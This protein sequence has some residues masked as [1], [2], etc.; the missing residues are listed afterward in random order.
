MHSMNEFLPTTPFDIYELA[1]FRLVVQNGSFT[2]AAAA[3]GLT[4]S[5]ITRQVQG[6]EGSLGL[7]LLERTTRSVHA[8]PAGEFLFRESGRVLGDVEQT[9]R[10]LREE[11][12]GARKEVHVG[13]SRTVSLAYLPGF[14]H[15]NVRKLPDVMC[16]V[17]YLRGTEVL[18]AIEENEMTLGVLALPRRLPRGL[19]VTHRFADAFALIAPIEVAEKFQALRRYRK[20]RVDWLHAQNW[21]LIEED[22]TT[23]CCLRAWMNRQGLKMDPT[24]QLDSFDLIINLVSLGMGISFVPIRALALY[25]RKR[26]IARLPL[27]HRFVRELVIVM[28]RRNDT[29]EHVVEFVRNVLF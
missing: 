19:S 11:F 27:E 4:Q 22:S 20:A 17:S 6:M 18:K 8:T 14:F 25:G 21:L 3:A 2:K 28:R 10:R 12:G 23:G 5:A 24:M 15:A 7:R 16:R 1:L 9:L 13:V 26:T 29:P